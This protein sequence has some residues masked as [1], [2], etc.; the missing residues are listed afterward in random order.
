M[1][2]WP[3]FLLPRTKDFKK[4]LEQGITLT[5][6]TLQTYKTTSTY[7]TDSTRQS[8]LATDYGAWL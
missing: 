6:K 7:T 8:G 1:C 5:N 2:M 4:K 3:F